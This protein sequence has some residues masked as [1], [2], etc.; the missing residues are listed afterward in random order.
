MTGQKLRQ[1]PIDGGVTTLG[2]CP[3][4]EAMVDSICRVARA[5]GYHGIVDAC[6]RY[7]ARDGQWNLLDVNP[8]PGANFRLFVG[9]HGMDVVRALY[10]GSD[11]P[12]IAGRRTCLGDAGGWSKTRISLPSAP[13]EGMHPSHSVVGS[14]CCEVCPSW[15]ISRLT[16]HGLPRRRNL[17][18]SRSG[19]R[20]PEAIDTARIAQLLRL[21]YY[22]GCL[23]DK[24]CYRRSGFDV[25]V[26][27]ALE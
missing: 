8:R 11:R 2:I 18:D 26:V 10:L 21:H 20:C 23:I 1:L 4:C 17:I 19:T 24:R 14:V 16:I 9:K 27:P 3:P 6:F 7:D 22:I 5:V 13:A 25:N 12:E 15:P